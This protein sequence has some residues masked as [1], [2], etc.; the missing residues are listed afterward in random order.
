MYR[1][2]WFK[3]LSPENI[4]AVSSQFDIA[5]LHLVLSILLF[6]LG[7]SYFFQRLYKK[8]ECPTLASDIVVDNIYPTQYTYCIIQIELDEI[9]MKV[10]HANANA[11]NANNSTTTLP[12][13]MEPRVGRHCTQ[14][15]NGHL[16]H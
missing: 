1:S 5:I 7:L 3:A 13:K 12:T 15:C 4:E 11:T 6:V 16:G 9:Y 8:M 10:I 14:Q 2:A